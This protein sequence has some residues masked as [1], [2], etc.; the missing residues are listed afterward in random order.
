[1][2][3]IAVI[4][5]SM[6]D[7]VVQPRQPLVME[8]CNK[9]QITMSFG[10]SM[11]NV[12]WNCAAL[13]LETHF[14]SKFGRDET[15]LA[16]INEL[17]KKTAFVYGPVVDQDTPVFIDVQADPQGMFFSSIRPEFLFDQHDDLPYCVLRECRWGITDQADDGFLRRLLTQTPDTRWIFSGMIPADCWWSRFT[18]IVVN[19]QE[20]ASFAGSR[21]MAGAAR[22]LLKKGLS[23]LIITLDKEGVLL[24]DNQGIHPFAAPGEGAYPLGCGDAFCSGL[25]YGLNQGLTPEQ[26]ITPAQQAAHLV[27]QTPAALCED[28]VQLREMKDEEKH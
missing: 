16:I 7:L 20:M 15:G 21:P 8:S 4:G 22:D 24:I 5:T 23:W 17:Q 27:L 18:G 9:S 28:I 3:G 26:S 13:G 14:V 6:L 2:K 10:G 1:M 12:A 19:R 25:L 11:H